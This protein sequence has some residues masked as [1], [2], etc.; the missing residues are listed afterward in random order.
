M[1]VPAPSHRPAPRTLLVLGPTAG[2]KTALAV[3]LALRMPGGGECISADSMQ[4]YRG[5]D[6]GT[7]KPTQAERRGV[8][9]HMIDV[10]DPHGGAF[11]AADWLDGAR[12]AI[13][14][15]QGRGR[16]AVVVGG[17]NLSVKMLLEGMFDGPAP[18]P[19]LRARLE[20]LPTEMLRRDLEQA[21]P[22]TAARIHPND[23]R[24][25]VRAL[26][27]WLATGTPIS[28]LQRQWSDAPKG[29]PPGWDVVGLEWPV[30]AIN[31]RINARVR[32]MIG[33]GLE[34]EVMRLIAKGPL[35]RQAVEAVGYREV[36][37]H[38]AHECSIEEA[39]EAIRVRTRQY[40]RQQRTWLRRFRAIPGAVWLEGPNESAA[41]AAAR[42]IGALFGA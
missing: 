6:I 9:H 27:V 29:L 4:V 17:T 14:D 25:A 37:R 12:A 33:A 2:G 3:E 5:M 1:H 7:A 23:R 20:A 16:H 31:Q 35:N 38:F 42:V 34:A 28:A 8:A 22:L 19:A 32:G 39:A 24:R 40:A 30:D 15:V 21:D 41:S 18:D 13:A 10:A 11:T 36:L 26:E